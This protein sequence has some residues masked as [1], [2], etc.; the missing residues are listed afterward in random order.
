[1]SIFLKIRRIKASKRKSE[2]FATLSLYFPRKNNAK[3]LVYAFI[4][5]E[6]HL[7][8]N[9]KAN[10]LIRNNI[11]SL[12]GFVINVKRKKA[13]INSCKVT[14]SIDTRQRGQFLAKK[15]LTSQEIVILP[16][17]KAIIS[18][19][20]LLLPNNRDFMFHPAT[21][22]SLTLFIHIVDYQTSK[23]FIKKVS[24]ESF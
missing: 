19:F 6:I 12:E 22:P 13:L 9:L 16:N 23:V 2:E 1:M 24:N 7:V 21:Q 5:C 14:I 8:E 4:I 11:M 3:Q 15:L 10:L 18:L 20:P 17:S